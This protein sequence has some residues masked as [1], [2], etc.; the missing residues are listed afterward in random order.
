MMFIKLAFE[1][2]PRDEHMVHLHKDDIPES[3]S[4]IKAMK[5]QET[6]Y[7]CHDTLI[8]SPP[9]IQDIEIKYTQL[10]PVRT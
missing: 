6:K 10:T 1:Q 5:K 4:Q 2:L 7:H 8:I 9:S 3:I